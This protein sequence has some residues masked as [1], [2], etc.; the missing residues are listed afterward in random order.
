MVK[1][2]LGLGFEKGTL[3]MNPP[4]LAPAALVLVLAKTADAMDARN[5]KFSMPARTKP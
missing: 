3:P 1:L 2:G 4:A 5:S